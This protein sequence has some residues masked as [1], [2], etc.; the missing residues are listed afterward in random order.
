MKYYRYEFCRTI[1]QT[2]EDIE[3]IAR[4]EY[5]TQHLSNPVSHKEL[6]DDIIGQ[7]RAAGIV[8]LSITLPALLPPKPPKEGKQ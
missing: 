1:R 2:G 7:L 5:D 3:I 8:K 6:E 4:V